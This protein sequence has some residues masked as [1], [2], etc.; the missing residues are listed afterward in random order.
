MKSEP[1]ENICLVQRFPI[2]TII[3]ILPFSVNIHEVLALP[4]P[5][6]EW[7]IGAFHD[8]ETLFDYDFAMN[9]GNWAVVSKIGNGA[10]AGREDVDEDH[11]DLVKTPSRGSVGVIT[12]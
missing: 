8:E 6:C 2:D 10:W 4:K 7:R 3:R 1:Y 5:W 11:W 12:L 9:Y